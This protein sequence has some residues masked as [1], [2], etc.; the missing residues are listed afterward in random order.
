MLCIAIRALYWYAC[1]VS[2]RAA[3]LQWFPEKLATLSDLNSVPN[4]ICHDVYMHCSYDV[5]PK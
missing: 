2:K 3:I 5:A 4:S 1:C